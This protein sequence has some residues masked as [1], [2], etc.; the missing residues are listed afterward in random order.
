[1][2]KQIYIFPLP[3]NFFQVAEPYFIK[4][5]DIDRPK[6]NQQLFAAIGK[7]PP[8][9]QPVFG[10]PDDNTFN[11]LLENNIQI[12]FDTYNPQFWRDSFNQY[13]IIKKPIFISSLIVATHFYIQIDDAPEINSE[14][15]EFY[16]ENRD[17]YKDHVRK[18]MLQLYNFV[19][20]WKKSPFEFP[21]VLKCGSKKLQLDNKN[22]WIFTAINNYLDEYLRIED[23]ETSQLELELNYSTKTGRKA[24]NQ[25][26]TIFIYGIDKLFQDITKSDEISND[27]CR[28][29]RDYLKY[30]GLPISEDGFDHDD[31]IKNIRSRIRYL[32]KTNYQPNWFENNDLSYKERYW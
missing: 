3:A 30:V 27:E 13:E 12:E 18:E 23:V 22:N 19:N 21:M 24:N 20:D 8:E 6:V 9:K 16:D 17:I 26:Q 2:S 25:Y 11:T 29:I 7:L 32:R 5:F 10:I 15:V 31:D 4:Y 1:M 14:E 28:F